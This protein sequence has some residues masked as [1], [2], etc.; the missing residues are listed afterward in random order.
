[1]TNIFNECIL[2]TNIQL[3]P[4]EYDNKINETILEKLKS[5]VEGKC[6]KNGYVK[7]DSTIV[8]KRSIGQ[9]LQAQFNGNCTFKVSYKVLC[10]NPIEGMVVKCSVLNKNKM[11]L[12]CELYNLDPSPLTIILAKQ[13][14]L[15]NPKYEE[16]KVGASLD[17][18][19]IGI[20]FEYNDTQIS[21][22]GRIS[23]KMYNKDMEDTNEEEEY[24]KEE[25]DSFTEEDN[26]MEVEIEIPE[27]KPEI[28]SKSLIDLM[29][30]I[31]PD[32][33]EFV[34]NAD[35]VES[36]VEENNDELE[37]D[38]D[39]D[40]DGE[41]MNLE[42][43][44]KKNKVEIALTEE[45]E[46]IEKL[47]KKVYDRK[48]KTS[49]NPKCIK[50]VEQPKGRN[51]RKHFIT[52]YNYSLLNNLIVDY[53]EENKENPSQIFINQDYQF[54]DDMIK[55]VKAYLSHMTIEETDELTYVI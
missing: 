44:S 11:G 15:D 41:K 32:E 2:S 4:H 1:M 13:H 18:E 43:E 7:K 38:L 30:P 6:D 33:E 21:C 51:L 12:F 37:L 45:D 52:Y 26:D 54:K 16:I 20:K 8:L 47:T 27:T 50:L 9:F 34:Q 14:H 17:I 55:L 24:Y 53:F 29:N 36:D 23:D 19:I 31:R 22:I 39:L 40:F 5:K 35:D 42:E 3:R 49:S 25:S 48:I 28:K 46:K 10:C